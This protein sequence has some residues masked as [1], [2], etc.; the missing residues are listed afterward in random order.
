MNRVGLG[1]DAHA[2]DDNRPLVLGGLTIPGSPGLAG[3]SDADVVSHAIADAL[4]GAAN[5]GDI[6]GRFP[7]T[8]E[9]KGANSLALLKDCSAAVRVAGWLIDNVDCTVIAERPK[10]TIYRERMMENLASALDL[11]AECVS[12]KATTTD[13]M[14]F[15]GRG[16]GIGAIAVVLLGAD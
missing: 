13:G 14:G 16:E 15:T 9:W 4:L 1:F 12:L 2:F 6:G 11:S 10:L 8:E 3:H 7:P 5:L